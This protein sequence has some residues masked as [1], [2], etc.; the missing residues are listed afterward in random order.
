MSASGSASST[1]ST[2][3]PAIPDVSLPWLEQELARSDYRRPIAAAIAAGDADA[4]E[5]AARLALAP[6]PEFLVSIPA[7]TQSPRTATG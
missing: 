4:A 6:V 5:S 1:A 3:S 2:I 7:G